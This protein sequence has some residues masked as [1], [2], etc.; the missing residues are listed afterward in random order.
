LTDSRDDKL[1]IERT[2]GGLLFDSFCWILENPEFQQWRYNK[3]RSLLWI[4]GDAGK[5]KTMLLVG[6]I[7][8]LLLKEANLK[9]TANAGTLSYFLCQGT[10]SRLNNAT[11]I[12]RGL[13]YLLIIQQPSLITHI[14]KKYDHAGQKLFEDS[15]AF[16][17]LSEV[18][19]QM[20]EDLRLTPTY[21]VVDALDECEVGLPEL[22]DLI[23]QTVSEQSI[24]VKWIV[25]SRNRDDIKQRLGLDNSHTR[26][27]LELNAKHVSHAVDAYIDYKVSQLVSLQNDQALQKQVKDQMRERSDGTFLWVA[28]VFDELRGILRNHLSRVLKRI[29]KGLTPLYNHM[30]K[31]ILQQGEYLQL[32]LLALSTTTLVYRP[33]HMLEL[34]TLAGLQEIPDL[35]ELER[36]IHMCSSFLTI[37][38][39]YVYFIHQSAKDYLT[40]SASTEILP[41]GPSSIH[42]Y[43][44]SRSLDALSKTLRQDIYSLKNFGPLTS[45]VSPHLDPLAPIRYSCLFLIDHLCEVNDQDL[46]HRKELFDNGTIFAFLKTHFLHWLESLSLM[47]KLSDGV[48]SIRKLLHKVQ[49]DLIPPTIIS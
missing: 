34:R 21:L 37:R 25:S 35:S 8:E 41:A 14:R 26:L 32:C 22:L 5:G 10:D 33:L 12:L 6:I 49:V 19:Y 28:L 2:K 15:S 45:K 16:Y 27:S 18:F 23:T 43:I 40:T 42:Y 1:R 30:M 48:L 39:D 31:Q 29:P 20:L 38:D 3:Q 46:D 4:K 24:Q 17:S 7:N 44:F 9:Q 47:Y 36:V 13:I 11:A